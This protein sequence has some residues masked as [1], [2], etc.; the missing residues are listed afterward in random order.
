VRVRIVGPGAVG[1]LFGALLAEAGHEITLVGRRGEALPSEDAGVR[2]VLPDRW[3]RFRPHDYLAP[4]TGKVRSGEAGADLVVV[5]LRRDHLREL[6]STPGGGSLFMAAGESGE[7]APLLFL[8]CDE[9]DTEG[10]LVPPGSDRGS[11]HG[12][13]AG[14]AGAGRI[15]RGLTL[16][17]AVRLERGTVELGSGDS[18]FVTVKDPALKPVVAALRAGGIQTVVADSIEPYLGSFFLWQLLF[19]PMAMCR[20]TYEYF[21]SFAEGREMALAVIEEGLKILERSGGELRKLP[22]MDPREL[23]L[24]LRR[25]R[26]TSGTARFDPDRGYNSLLQAL[27]RGEKTEV[28]ELNERLV[29]LGGEAGVEAS[30]NWRLARKLGR[31]ARLG[32]YRDPAE[33][34][35]AL[36]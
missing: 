26:Q 4:S 9:R 12:R 32:F 35:L 25:A 7:A 27:L 30:W 1:T 17:T 33:L 21:L 11:R 31:V 16:W 15:L 14:A 5:A 10:L 6:R 8:N 29:K 18:A 22:V 23:V 28:R 13:S 19:L 20:A 36:A 24:R 3:L 2:V 34:Y